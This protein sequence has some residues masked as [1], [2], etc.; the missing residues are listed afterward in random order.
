MRR[1]ILYAAA[2]IVLVSLLTTALAITTHH[3]RAPLCPKCNA[4]DAV[5]G[6]KFETTTLYT[7]GSCKRVFYG[8]PRR[9]FSWAEAIAEWLDDAPVVE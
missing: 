7:C 4:P 1:L 5:A 9:D 6:A 2:A 8:P 3:A